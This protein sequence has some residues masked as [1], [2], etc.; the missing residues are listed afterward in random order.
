MNSNN[1]IL[2][3]DRKHKNTLAAIGQ[4]GLFLAVNIVL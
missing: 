4:L 3:K 1:N 2:L